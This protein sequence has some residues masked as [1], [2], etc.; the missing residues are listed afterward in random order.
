MDRILAPFRQ[1]KM[2]NTLFLSNVFFSLHY[3][4]II[5]VN[6]SLLNNYFDETH[7]SSLYIIGSIFTTI[8]LIY[9]S[10]ILEKIGS[11]R[12]LTYVLFLELL[13]TIGLFISATPFLV[14]LYFLIH[15]IVVSLIYFNMDIYI[16]KASPNKTLTGSIRATYMTIANLAIIIGPTIVSFLVIGKNYDHVYMVSSI[17]LLPIFYLILKLKNIKIDALKHIDLRQTIAE[18]AANRNLYNIF[19]AGF[20]L[21]LFYAFMVVYMPIYLSNYIGFSW[22]EIGIIFTIML[23]PF[24]LFELPIGEL[25]DDKYGEKEFLTIGLIVM[26]LSCIFIAFV[27]VKVFWIWATIL[28]ISRIG[29]SF[30][31]VSTESY[32][33]K[34][35][36]S[37]KTDIISFFRITRPVSFI[38]APII[39]TLVFQFIPFQY[40]FLV[41]GILMIIGVR[42]SLALKDT[43]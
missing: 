7:I 1:S 28:F 3:A 11:Y 13:S 16:E 36:T 21:Q 2:L 15:H 35:V 30:V 22:S 23:L 18:Y 32:F 37:E 24:V 39:A 17:F 4:L 29:A 26:G 12:F 43:R 10:R 25:E 20:L 41:V 14:G 38:V 33:F 5:Y 9:A 19:T 8:L 42:Y 40:L 34:Q 27:T 31:E 6:S